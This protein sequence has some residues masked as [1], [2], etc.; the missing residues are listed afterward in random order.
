[1]LLISKIYAATLKVPEDFGFR[2][3]KLKY[4]NDAVDVIIISK[5][6]EERIPKPLFLFCQDSLPKPVIK[7]SEIGLYEILHFNEEALL[8][9]FHIV[10]VGKPYIP[11]ISNVEK[12]SEDFLFLKDQEK[13]IPPRGY[14]DRNY[15]DYYVFRNNSI[16]KQLFKYRWAKTTKLLVAGQ[17]EGSSIAVKMATLNKKITHLIYLDGNP[18]GKISSQ[19]FNCGTQNNNEQNPSQILFQYKKILANSREIQYDKLE[20]TKAIFS[21]SLPQRDNLMALKIPI[22]ICCRNQDSDHKFNLLFQMEVTRE[23][24]QNIDFDNY[25]SREKRTD[26]DGSE[27]DTTVSKIAT[28]NWL[29]WWNERKI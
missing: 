18:Y 4:L 3:I 10:I 13:R 27:I 12:L 7:Y 23:G 21:F 14:L 8:D 22:L 1:M 16:L 2:H 6:G 5:Q 20:T 15:L 26:D 9:D 29:R 28:L 17:G 11:I 25:Y 19:I 24:N